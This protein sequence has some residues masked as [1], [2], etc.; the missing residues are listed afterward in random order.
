MTEKDRDMLSNFTG[1][2]SGNIELWRWGIVSP[3]EALSRIE[4]D[5]HK[6]EEAEEKVMED[7]RKKAGDL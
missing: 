2:V 5:L 1:R 3:E 6:L 7:I 4:T